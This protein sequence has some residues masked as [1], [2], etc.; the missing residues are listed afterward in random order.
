VIANAGTAGLALKAN[1]TGATFTGNI[2][3]PLVYD[4][5][6]EMRTV[7][8]STAAGAVVPADHGKFRVITTGI[9]INS[10]TSFTPGQNCTLYANTTSATLTITGT[11][12]TMY[13]AGNATAVA[14][15]ALKGRGMCTIFCTASGEYI[16]AGN[17]S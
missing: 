13:I 4:A 14:T 1:L 7:P 16:L 6:G 15:A 3:A 5:A 2:S 8:Q 17:V 10:S 12:V 11:G 9:T